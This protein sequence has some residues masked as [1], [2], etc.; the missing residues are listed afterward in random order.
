M[1]NILSYQGNANQNDSEIFDLFAHILTPSTL[2]LDLGRSVQC[3]DVG[4][5][6]CFHLL[7]EEG[8]M[9]IFKIIISL[10][11]KQVKI[12]PHSSIA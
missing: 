5:S 7:L 4:L 12:G 10:T 1:F 3:S 6:L 8:S 9:V 11:T 2:Q